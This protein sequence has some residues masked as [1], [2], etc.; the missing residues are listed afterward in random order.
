ARSAFN[1]SW[2]ASTAGAGPHTLVV[3]YRTRCGW[4]SLSQPVEVEGPTIMLNIDT[5]AQGAPI[6]APVRIEG[7]AAD[8]R[9]TLGTGVERID[10]Y[11][12]GQ[13]TTQGIPLGEVT[14]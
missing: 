11:L 12:D 8:P 7:W 2:D 6:S 9:A 13:I 14:Y 3:L 1:L 5:P 10:L 4:F